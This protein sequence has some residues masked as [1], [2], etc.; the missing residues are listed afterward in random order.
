MALLGS[1]FDP[2]VTNVYTALAA[3][4]YLDEVQESISSTPTP[5]VTAWLSPPISIRRSTFAR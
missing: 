3:K 5:A 2:G 4:K 1:G